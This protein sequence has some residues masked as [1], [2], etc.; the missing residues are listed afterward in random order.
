MG[1]EGKGGKNWE[2]STETYA[3]P[4]VK[5]LGWYKSNLSFALLNFVIWYWNTF[6]NKCGY[7]IKKI[8]W[9][10][11]ALNQERYA[12]GLH[13]DPWSWFLRIFSA[14]KDL[15]KSFVFGNHQPIF[16]VSMSLEGCAGGRCRWVWEVY[17]IHKW[18][19]TNGKIFFLFWLSN[20][21]F[22]IRIVIHTYETIISTSYSLLLCH[23]LTCR[24]EFIFVWHIYLSGISISNNDLCVC[25]Y[26]NTILFGLPVL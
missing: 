11:R 7:V 16:S 8:R 1:T 3:L 5:L 26:A 20:I 14:E 6:L 10:I 23:K 22:Y 2:G 17:Y 25:F 18:D 13:F 15:K 9:C 24:S 12:N 21:P 4:C 19:H